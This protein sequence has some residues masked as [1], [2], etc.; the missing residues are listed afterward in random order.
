MDPV[1]KLAM[2]LQLDMTSI[3]KVVPL[4]CRTWR[5]W[6]V[7]VLDGTSSTSPSSVKGAADFLM[8]EMSIAIEGCKDGAMATAL[9]RFVLRTNRNSSHWKV[10]VR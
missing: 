5:E 6:S 2:M 7:K 8:G 4:V 3:A 9:A 10:D 1:I